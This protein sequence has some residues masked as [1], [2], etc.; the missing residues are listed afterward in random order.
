MTAT[1]QVSL[2]AEEN[3]DV[4]VAGGGPAGTAAAITAARSGLR[5]AL[6]EQLG[7]LGGLGSSGLVCAF[8]PMA[9]GKEPLVG[10][11]CRT[12]VDTMYQRGFL[13]IDEKPEVCWKAYLHWTPFNPEGLKLVLDELTAG[14]GV[15]IRFFTR[16]VDVESDRREQVKSVITHDVEGFKRLTASAF[17][18]ATGD[19][20]LSFGAGAK[21][22]RA[23]VDSPRIMPPTL[24]QLFSNVDWS[25]WK[26]WESQQRGLE[27]AL[28]DNFFKH[29]TRLLPGLS[30]IGENTGYLNGGHVFGTDPLSAPS[31]SEA[32]RRGREIAAEFRAFYRKY[33]E[34]CADVETIATATL[35]GARETRRVASERDLTLDDYLARRQF[36]DQI[37]RFNKY[38]DIHPYDD[39]PEEWERFSREKE[40]LRLGDG[41]CFG[42]PYG[43]LVAKG[44]K[45]LWVA[46]RCAGTDVPMQGTVRVMPTCYMMGEAAGAGA[47]LAIKNH[48]GANEIDRAEVAR[49]L[50][51][52]SR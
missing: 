1:W 15:D 13:G 40:N 31:L 8:D 47:A 18:D 7:C 37:G 36:P 33:V 19:A 29:P 5:V 20:I 11:L 30:R 26:N 39:S 48:V 51:N 52:A 21:T 16:L 14:A 22:Y 38:V 28:A 49:E 32:M 24:P 2:G 23:G 10:G 25:K 9:N 12:I 3:F 17:I 27:Q 42:L 50:A 34:G 43:M 45:N 4:V 44:W 35:L 46:G 41:E 6:I